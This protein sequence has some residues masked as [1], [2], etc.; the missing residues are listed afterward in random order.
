M[1]MNS[2]NHLP[3]HPASAGKRILQG[4]AIAFILIAVFLFSAG[5]PDPNWPK[6]WMMKPL[7]VVPLAGALGGLFY[8]NMD[9]LRNQGGFRRVL[10][11][12]ISIL[13]YMVV[14]WL[15]TVIGLNGTM[16]N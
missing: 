7:I 4:A 2:P 12:I 5:E 13:V 10:A 9:H 14:L 16:W 15:G 8:Y 6:L 3:I 11:A 1:T